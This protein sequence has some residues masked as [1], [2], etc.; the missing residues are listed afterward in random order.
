MVQRPAEEASMDTTET[1]DEETTEEV[2][3]GFLASI[4]AGGMSRSLLAEMAEAG[5]G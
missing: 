5:R 1:T 4:E 2:T 3:G